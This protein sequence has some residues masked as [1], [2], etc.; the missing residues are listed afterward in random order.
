MRASPLCARWLASRSTWE[1][2]TMNLGTLAR[3]VRL[4]VAGSGILFASGVA[5][6]APAPDGSYQQTCRNITASRG[7]LTA[8]CQTRSG[9]WTSSTL[10][11]YRDCSSDISNQNGTLTCSQ[12]SSNSNGGG[13]NNWQ[14]N[15]N[16]SDNGGSYRDRNDDSR[17]GNDDN[18]RPPG[19]LSRHL[20]EHSRRRQRPRSGMP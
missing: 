3:V 20:P 2:D 14:N 11:N 18:A 4:C 10:E 6:A 17:G 19:K 9:S 12:G 1:N 5:F 13:T 8:E 7:T 16:Q 15:N